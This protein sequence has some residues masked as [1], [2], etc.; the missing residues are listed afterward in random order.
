M[1]E[2]GSA[3]ATAHTNNTAADNQVKRR[4]GSEKNF[5]MRRRGIAFLTFRQIKIV[6]NSSLGFFTPL[7]TGGR[8][9]RLSPSAPAPSTAYIKAG[10]GREKGSAGIHVVLP[11]TPSVVAP[12]PRVGATGGKVKKG[13]IF[14]ARETSRLHG[15]ESRLVRETSL[16]SR[17][18]SRWLRDGRGFL[19]DASRGGGEGSRFAREASLSLRGRS[20]AAGDASL[21]LGP[22]ASRARANS[23]DPGK[24]GLTVGGLFVYLL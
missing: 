14:G 10:G 9:S 2:T 6:Q 21:F 7:R 24:Q 16:S 17:D 8:G 12:P 19:R 13:R 5:P 15:E 20:P 4:S 3:A 1:A 23:R 22:T 11:N 18:H